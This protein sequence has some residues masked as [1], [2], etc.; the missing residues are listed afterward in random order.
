MT[1]H[2][3]QEKPAAMTPGEEPADTVR[4]SARTG[5]KQ[6]TG[7]HLPEALVTGSLLHIL[8]VADGSGGQGRVGDGLATP[9]GRRHL[10]LL[11]GSEPAEVRI[12]AKA[13]VVDRR[14]D[15][16]EEETADHGLAN[17]PVTEPLE[18]SVHGAGE[19]PVGEGLAGWI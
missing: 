14:H 2:T 1:T 17:R 10:P 6:T 7:Q 9:Y 18:S 3:R 12:G 19:Q 4:P 13:G 11:L 16:T 15:G 5:T 8:G